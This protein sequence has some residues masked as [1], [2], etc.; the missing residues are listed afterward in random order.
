MWEA[1]T[2]R[3]DPAVSIMGQRVK[4]KGTPGHCG[5]QEAAQCW[6]SRGVQGEGRE[7]RPGEEWAGLWAVSCRVGFAF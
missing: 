5:A 4:A 6:R 1:P 3:A 2:I 7:A